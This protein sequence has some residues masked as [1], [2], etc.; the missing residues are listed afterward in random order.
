MVVLSKEEQA[1]LL[2]WIEQNIKD[3]CKDQNPKILSNYIKALVMRQ[4]S[5]QSMVALLREFIDDSSEPF[6][7][8][9]EDRLKRRD[10]SVDR[11]TEMSIAQAPKPNTAP[12]R[13]QE[14]SPAS[15]SSSSSESEERPKRRRKHHHRRHK[16]RSRRHRSRH[17]SNSD[18]SDEDSST[19]EERS[20]AEQKRREHDTSRLRERKESSARRTSSDVK[21]EGSRGAGGMR[22]MESSDSDVE[23][24]RQKEWRRPRRSSLGEQ[25]TKRARDSNSMRR[26]RDSEGEIE[27]R[28][29]RSREPEPKP[30]PKLVERQHYVV[31]VPGLAENLNTIGGILREFS[32]FGEI[33]AVQE[34]REKGYALVEFANLYAAFKAV[35]STRVFFSNEYIRPFFAV[36]IGDQELRATEAEYKRRKEF[37]EELN[38][39]RLE[40]KRLWQAQQKINDMTE[41]ELLTEMVAIQEKKIKEFEQSTDAAERDMIKNEID[42]L[43]SMIDMLAHGVL[44]AT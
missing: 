38:R 28:A 7:D 6:V 23:T 42:S 2:T 40:Q 1:A 13:V 11:P 30:E 43:S 27:R 8:K 22:E 36:P 14:M 34:N 5:R 35:R 33:I 32:R 10:F 16:S 26:Q 39:K 3:Y 44:S 17:D 25:T 19:S 18:S 31:C 15:S 20:D 41:E 21:P 9:L 24:K 29:V 37:A 12:T 4:A